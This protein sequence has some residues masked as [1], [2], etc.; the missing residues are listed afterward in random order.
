[1]PRD[2]SSLLRVRRL[3]LDEARRALAASLG[4]EAVAEA[5]AR[6][7]ERAI[8]AESDAA[9]VLT[10]DD[11]TVEAFA[12][13]LPQARRRADLAR[14]A[15]AT[16]QAETSRARAG[17]TLARAALASALQACQAAEHAAAE[18]SGGQ[19]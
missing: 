14:E 4:A 19:A 17:L 1:M 7:A 10:A 18:A 6:D 12:A 2:L 8:E 15:V 9:H 13:W 16:A 11:S 5:T 3:A